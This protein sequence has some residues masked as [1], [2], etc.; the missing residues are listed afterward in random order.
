[1]KLFY[2]LVLLFTLSCASQERYETA[3]QKSERELRRELL[4]D[5][6]TRY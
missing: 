1:M 4:R 2:P 5:R 6:A 3:Q